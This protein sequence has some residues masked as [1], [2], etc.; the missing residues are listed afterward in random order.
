MK[1]PMRIDVVTSKVSNG[2]F[3]VGVELRLSR[4]IHADTVNCDIEPTSVDSIFVRLASKFNS[5]RAGFFPVKNA[6]ELV[7]RCSNDTNVSAILIMTA[8]VPPLIVF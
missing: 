3:S 7:R 1:R 8:F 4:F 2:S 6:S 5:F